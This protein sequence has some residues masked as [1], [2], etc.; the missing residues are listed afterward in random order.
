[1]D[2]INNAPSNETLDYL[3][4]LANAELQPLMDA[5]Q[6]VLYSA[7]DEIVPGI[8]A[9]AAPGH[10]P[11]HMAFLL[12]SNDRRLL[13]I[14]DVAPH[15]IISLQRPEWHFV[16]HLDQETAIETRQRLLGRAVDERLQIFS[17]HFPF[18]GVGYIDHDGDGFRFLPIS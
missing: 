9:I 6:L 18:P 8:Q 2:F 14:E 3:I 7:E 5:D 13:C 4:G 16:F 17:Y 1:M 15:P 11:G 10:T 12:T